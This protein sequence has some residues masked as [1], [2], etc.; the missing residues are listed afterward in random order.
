MR[1][2]FFFGFLVS[3][4]HNSENLEA[5]RQVYKNT[6]VDPG[7]GLNECWGHGWR[8]YDTGYAFGSYKYAHC[9]YDD[10]SGMQRKGGILEMV[11]RNKLAGKYS[12]QFSCMW[13]SSYSTGGRSSLPTKLPR[14]IS[15]G[16]PLF[17][18]NP[19]VYPPFFVHWGSIGCH[20]VILIFS[21]K[22][23]FQM[24]Q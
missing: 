22:L 13:R 8:R 12:P 10:F 23:S 18:R 20:K 2:L 14:P 7:V 21:M 19:Q 5:E 1:V 17:K 16:Q 15:Q 4:P 3:S 11:T 24:I 6:W 9:W